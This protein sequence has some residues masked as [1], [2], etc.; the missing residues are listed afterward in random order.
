M[1]RLFAS[2]CCLLSLMFFSIPVA[3]ASPNIA[4]F[5]FHSQLQKNHVVTK[6]NTFYRK[7]GGHS[8]RGAHRSRGGVYRGGHRA[9]SHSFRSHHR[10]QVKVYRSHHRQGV[11]YRHSGYQR[12]HGHY[13][14]NR[15]SFL[16]GLFLGLML[17]EIYDNDRRC[18]VYH[19]GH[20][21]YGV[22]VRGGCYVNTGG[23]NAVYRYYGY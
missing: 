23:H 12:H 19:R 5:S 7:H 1:I 13:R 8:Y 22:L 17:N 15:D 16:P 14:G 3:K 20:M 11:T 9:R 18:R 21:H 4:E 10:P 6:Y 2:T